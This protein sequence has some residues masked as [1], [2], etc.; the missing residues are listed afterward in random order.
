MCGLAMN[1]AGFSHL[2]KRVDCDAIV[3]HLTLTHIIKRKSEPAKL[4]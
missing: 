1:I 3:D 2:L 4:E